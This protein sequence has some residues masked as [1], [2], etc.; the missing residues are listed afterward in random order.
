[1]I[2]L[3]YLMTY[4]YVQLMLGAEGGA[5]ADEFLMR[6]HG[7]LLGARAQRAAG[8]R[9]AA[10]R[11]S[12][13]PKQKSWH[14]YLKNASKIYFLY[15]SYLQMRRITSLHLA[16]WLDLFMRAYPFLS[17][18]FFFLSPAGFSWR[19]ALLMDSCVISGAGWWIYP[20]IPP[21]W[22]PLTPAEWTPSR[23]SIWIPPGAWTADIL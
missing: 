13:S 5:A 18:F 3:I 10:G 19:R 2:F 21:A 23:W 16:P 6:T 7:A 12:A 1:M 9:D 17:F 15:V 8:A 14:K 20:R 4:L 11:Y 22:S